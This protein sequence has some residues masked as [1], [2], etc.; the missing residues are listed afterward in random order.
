MHKYLIKNKRIF[1]FFLMIFL[2][3]L[4]F[5]DKRN[6]TVIDDIGLKRHPKMSNKK[7]NY[8][9]IASCGIKKSWLA[10]IVVTNE[11]TMIA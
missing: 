10:M 8:I 6:E 3:K 1:F 5:E 7:N 4:Q 11:N 2:K 9:I